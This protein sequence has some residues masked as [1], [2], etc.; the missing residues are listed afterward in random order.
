M[1]Y[2]EVVLKAGSEI[3]IKKIITILKDI[4]ENYGLQFDDNIVFKEI[5]LFDKISNGELRTE[6]LEIIKETSIKKLTIPN[7]TFIQEDY[8][9]E[10]PKVRELKLHLNFI[11]PDYVLPK[12]MLKACPNIEILDLEQILLNK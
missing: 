12:A 5:N 9:I 2:F 4:R 7:T 8:I 3:D 11:L 6:L 10:M 1:K